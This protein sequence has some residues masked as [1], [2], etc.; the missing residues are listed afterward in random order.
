MSG[1]FSGIKIK[2]LTSKNR[3]VMPPMCMYS[4][5]DDGQVNDWHI[6]HYTSRAIGG[7]GLIIVEATAVEPRGRISAKDLGIWSDDQVEGLRQLVDQIHISGSQ[8][9]LQMAHAGRKC[10]VKEESIIAPSAMA[11]SDEYQKPEAMT[12]HEINHVVESFQSAAKRALEAGFD[13]IEIHAAHGY[14]INQFLSPLTNQ[15]IDSYGGNL[16]KR[17]KFLQ[18]VLA[19]VGEVWDQNKPISL[20]V[21]AEEY[22]TEGNHPDDLVEIINL[23]KMGGIDLIHVSS[24]GVV[25]T[26]IPLY[27]GYQLTFA[28]TIKKNTGL[29]VIAGGLITKSKMAEEIIRNRRADFVFVGR[30]LLRNPYW[31]LHASQKL[32]IDI[33][34]PEQYERSK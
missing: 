28:E 30:E 3:I 29:P 6:V 18:E 21:S 25:N 20:R 7:V 27:P 14:L 15:R 5:G 24:G 10:K 31:S 11:F 34:W 2:D 1:L 13:G 33:P 12:Q 32:G 8:V 17:T 9:I 23:V 16:E 4:A 19:A 22:Q 26:S